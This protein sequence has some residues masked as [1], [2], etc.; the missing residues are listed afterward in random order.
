MKKLWK[1]EFSE[2][3]SGSE[4]WCEEDTIDDAIKVAKKYCG[5]REI[6]KV[7]LMANQITR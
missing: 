5:E 6:I 7:E 2:G 3:F 4:I 1:V